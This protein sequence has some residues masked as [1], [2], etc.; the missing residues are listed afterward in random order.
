MRMSTNQSPSSAYRS[1]EIQLAC[2]ITR[3]AVFQLEGGIRKSEYCTMLCAKHSVRAINNKS[4][5]IPCCADNQTR[6][7]LPSSS[8][9]IRGSDAFQVYQFCYKSLIVGI[10]PAPISSNTSLTWS[11][12]SRI[13]HRN[14]PPHEAIKSASWVSC[15]VALKAATKSCGK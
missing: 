8:L 13:V 10:S 15:N 9:S 3:P 6:I 11:V 4:I 2:Q 14:N 12:L 1:E 5:P 7:G